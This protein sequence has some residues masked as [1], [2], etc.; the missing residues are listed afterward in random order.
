MR[1]EF[2]RVLR[3]LSS[4]E[5]SD[6]F[7]QTDAKTVLLRTYYELEDFDGLTYLM[8]SF[9]M[10]LRRNKQLSDYQRKLYLNLIKVAQILMRYRLGENITLAEIE[11][12][13]T[14]TPDIAALTWVKAKIQELKM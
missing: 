9:R 3:M 4:V 14:K 1:K 6:V 2:S 12:R 5:F 10:F 7:Y 8:G 13:I 11:A